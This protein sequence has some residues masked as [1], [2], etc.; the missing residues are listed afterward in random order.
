MRKIKL[1]GLLVSKKTFSVFIRIVLKV[2]YNI[3]DI[4]RIDEILIDKYEIS[5][6]NKPAKEETKRLKYLMYHHQI[7]KRSI[8]LINDLP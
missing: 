1:K 2:K 4:A 6:L 3:N 8:H 7:R 5:K